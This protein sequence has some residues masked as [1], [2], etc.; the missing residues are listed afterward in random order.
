MEMRQDILDPPS[1]VNRRHEVQAPSGRRVEIT[2]CLVPAGCC[3]ATRQAPR[4]G[5]ACNVPDDQ[6]VHASV[7]MNEAIVH[8]CHVLSLR[9][10]ELCT[11][12]LGDCLAASPITLTLRTK[13]FEDFVA[14]K[15]LLAGA[16]RFALQ[17]LG[18]A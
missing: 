10:R 17:K 5:R 14:E 6:V 9:V 11:R 13:A 12:I 15:R 3:G 18:F 16:L 4:H 2:H 8:A 7:V 1:L